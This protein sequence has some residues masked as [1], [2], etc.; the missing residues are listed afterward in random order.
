VRKNHEKTGVCHRP[1][2]PYPNQRIG[3]L[4]R[5]PEMWDLARFLFLWRGAIIAVGGNRRF[6]EVVSGAFI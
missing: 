5:K 2:I 1:T 3:L 4:F 6:F